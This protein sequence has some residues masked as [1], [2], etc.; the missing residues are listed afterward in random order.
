MSYPFLDYLKNASNKEKLL[1]FIDWDLKGIMHT[2][3]SV[4]LGD[5]YT[6]KIIINK[7][8]QIENIRL[9]KFMFNNDILKFY[10]WSGIKNLI[11]RTKLFKYLS[12]PMNTYIII[13]VKNMKYYYMQ[14]LKS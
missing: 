9:D 3:I 1:E 14:Q 11:M 12:A 5:D 6:S 13:K 2:R 10:Y 8:R 7:I 4:L